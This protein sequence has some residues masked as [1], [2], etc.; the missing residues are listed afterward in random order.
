M[1]D[2]LQQRPLEQEALVVEL[3]LERAGADAAR[4]AAGLGGAQVEQLAASSPSRRRPATLDALVAL[5]ADQLAA[6]PA[7]EHLGD[8]GLADAGLALEQ[9]RAVQGQREEDRGGQA[10]VG[11]VAVQAERLRDVGG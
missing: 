11:E 8:L 5:Q 10:V 6:G 2:G 3:L 1:V 4:L 7:A 9:Q